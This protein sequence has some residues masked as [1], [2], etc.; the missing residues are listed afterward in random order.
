MIGW[1]EKLFSQVSHLPLVSSVYLYLVHL[2]WDGGRER[3]LIHVAKLISR[4]LL[5][6][7]SFPCCVYRGSVT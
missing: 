2:H 4:K 1:Q 5:A 7:Y 6:V 3:F